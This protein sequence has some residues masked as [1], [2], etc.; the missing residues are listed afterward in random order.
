MSKKVNINLNLVVQ[1][2]DE[3]V[4]HLSKYIA[5]HFWQMDELADVVH[6]HELTHI[7]DKIKSG[8]YQKLRDMEINPV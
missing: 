4:N 1:L 2:S 5:T 7:R 6:D 8:V 3:E